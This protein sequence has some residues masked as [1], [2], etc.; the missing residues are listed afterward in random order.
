MVQPG[1]KCAGDDPMEL[2]KSLGDPARVRKGKH[3]TTTSQESKE[4]DSRRK[5]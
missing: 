3:R 4:A 5:K 1:V 2:D